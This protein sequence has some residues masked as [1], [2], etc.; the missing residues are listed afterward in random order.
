MGIDL[1]DLV[2]WRALS[3]GRKWHPSCRVG[4]AFQRVESFVATDFDLECLNNDR[5]RTR[6]LRICLALSRYPARFS[7]SDL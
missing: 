3:S 1:T 4:G 2:A 7:L 6:D 5:Q